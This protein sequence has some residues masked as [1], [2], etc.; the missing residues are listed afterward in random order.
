[1]VSVPP[2]KVDG[3]LFGSGSLREESLGDNGPCTPKLK[4]ARGTSLQLPLALSTASYI[5]PI[6]PAISASLL[7][8]SS[9]AAVSSSFMAF[10]SFSP[11]AVILLF[12]DSGLGA[13]QVVLVVLISRPAEPLVPLSLSTFRP[14]LADTFTCGKPFNA[15]AKEKSPE[16][17]AF[18]SNASDLAPPRDT[19]SFADTDLGIS[20]ANSSGPALNLKDTRSLNDLPPPDGAG[21]GPGCPRPPAGNG[22]TNKPGGNALGAL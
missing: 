20:C 15:I 16:V 18:S 12:S 9:G 4:V 13:L 22:G 3:R 19:G 5:S 6:A 17:S 21:P 1:M 10:F 7:R 14:T 8:R 11:A 2:M